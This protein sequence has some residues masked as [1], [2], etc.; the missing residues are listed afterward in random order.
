MPHLACGSDYLLPE[1]V[2]VE[3]SDEVDFFWA[4]PLAQV[5]LVPVN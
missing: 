1:S 4:Q 5:A 3:F 2:L